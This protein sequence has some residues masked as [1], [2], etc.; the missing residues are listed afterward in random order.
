[1]VPAGAAARQLVEDPT[2]SNGSEM[3]ALLHA[4]NA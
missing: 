2:V 4:L 3:T 1:M